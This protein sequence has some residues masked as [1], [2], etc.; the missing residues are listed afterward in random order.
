VKRILLLLD[1]RENESLL[2]AELAGRHEV[3]TARGDEGLDEEFDLCVIGGPALDRLWEQVEAR[4]ERDKPIFLPF[5]L[6]T[7]RPDVKMI[8]RHLWRSVD[9]LIVT[10]IEKPELRAR[11]EILLRARSMS[12]ALRQRVVDAE[13]AARSRDEV[14]AM[15]SHDLR[16][17]LNLVLSNASFLLDTASERLEPKQNQQLEMIRRA[18]DQMN[19]L[20][21]DLLEVSGIE[22][23][24][25]SVEAQP[26][27]VEPLV[28]EACSS[29]EHA[30]RER[31]IRLSWDVADGIPPVWADRDRILQV[32]GNL[33]GN[34]LKFTPAG[35]SIEVRVEPAGELVRFAVADT[36]P[37]ISEEDLP[38]VFDR[39]WQASRSRQGGAGLGLAI[40][41]GIVA[42]HGGELWAESEVGSGS[43]F[44]FMLP[45]ARRPTGDG[46]R[47]SQG[48]M[49][50]E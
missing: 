5:L 4:K 41:H 39:F 28:R 24:G 40:A 10:P 42:A 15:V 33:I 12:L 32:L 25:V 21:Q 37:G 18:A 23:G 27:P 8:T 1:Q 38:H 26:E 47:R 36:G 14:L 34:A 31:K 44:V 7:S 9:E 22:A 48:T 29:L 19:R 11:V 45:V 3:L 50:A 6:A 46:E 2:A 35:G 49:G 16:N 43:T 17:P 20:I 13:E 30:T